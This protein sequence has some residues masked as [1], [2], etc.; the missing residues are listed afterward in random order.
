MTSTLQASTNAKSNS[1]LDSV[2]FNRRQR[3]LSRV[4]STLEVASGSVYKSKDASGTH[5]DGRPM[6]NMPIKSSKHAIK[7]L[8]PG[9]DGQR[10][11]SLSRRNR[12]SSR[13]PARSNS[14]GSSGSFERKQAGLGSLPQ[15]RI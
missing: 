12:S 1:L 15:M 2:H 13:S 5:T 3:H 7:M 10:K 4:H 11:A 6:R 8:H 14:P 9:H